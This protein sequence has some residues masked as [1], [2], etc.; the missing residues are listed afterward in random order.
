MNEKLEMGI[1][2]IAGMIIGIAIME[3]IKHV[4]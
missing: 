1:C 2:I 4:K 3:L